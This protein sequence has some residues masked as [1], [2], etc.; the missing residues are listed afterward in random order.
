MFILISFEPILAKACVW[1]FAFILH[2]GFSEFAHLGKLWI[3]ILF[4]FLFFLF[5]GNT[6]EVHE[7][8]ETVR[9]ALS[10]EDKSSILCGDVMRQVKEALAPVYNKTWPS[11]LQ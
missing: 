10:D 3:N 1:F 6:S 9:K 4:Y 2:G 8:L 11:G 7:N 5:F